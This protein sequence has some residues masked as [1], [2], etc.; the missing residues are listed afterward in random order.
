MRPAAAGGPWA[1]GVGGGGASPPYGEEFGRPISRHDVAFEGV[2]VGVEVIG[3]NA[4][5]MGGDVGRLA[6]SSAE[7]RQKDAGPSGVGHL[8]QRKRER[9][10]NVTAADRR[11][12]G[13]CSACGVRSLGQGGGGWGGCG[14]GWEQ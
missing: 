10:I 3:T 11:T 4:V 7:Q 2:Q 13:Y 1:Q 6:G 12:G 14:V 8:G 5:H 9:E